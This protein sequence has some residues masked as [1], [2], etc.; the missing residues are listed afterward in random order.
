MAR[1]LLTDVLAEAAVG[2]MGTLI[3]TLLAFLSSKKSAITFKYSYIHG[4]KKN[5]L[6]I[7]SEIELQGF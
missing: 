1:P 6:N 7:Y 5:R 2:G 4:F 3:I